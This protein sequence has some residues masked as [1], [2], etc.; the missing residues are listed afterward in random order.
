VFR[1]IGCALVTRYDDD[2]CTSHAFQRSREAGDDPKELAAPAP[3][4]PAI[5]TKPL[6]MPAGR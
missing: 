5:G 1:A 3:P 6:T 4:L 2:Y